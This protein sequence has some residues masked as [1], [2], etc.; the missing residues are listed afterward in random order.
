M[1]QQTE[2]G[3]V[4][5]IGNFDGVHRGHQAVLAA[6]AR[7]A[8]GL[9]LEAALLT[10]SPHPREALGR[11]V[12]PVLTALGRKLSLV[13]EAAPE[14]TP[15]VE[16]FDLAFAE[17]S[18][19]EFAGRVLAEK[20]RAKVVIVGPNFRFGKGRAGSYA[21]L[22][23]L[24]ARLGFTTHAPELVQDEKGVLSSTRVREALAA[25]DLD[26]AASILGRPHLVS[27]T[28]VEGD[29]RGRTIGFPTC[30]L[31]GIV[32]A[33]PAFGVYAVLVEREIEARGAGEPWGSAVPLAKGVAN[34]GVRPTVKPGETRP[35][36]EVHLFD[37]DQDLY[38][39]R[40]R[41]RLVA[42]LRA[43][44]R[45]SG[46]AELK[47]QIAKDAEAARRRLAE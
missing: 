4:V 26:E 46:L 6:A 20:L 38:G 39:A 21:T 25:G 13:R 2:P 8:K 32:E 31:A 34:I 11:P 35:S 16:R 1:E 9:G 7:E 43:E 23:E 30:N 15:I 14:V 28:V 45:F 33:L 27:G 22:G 36:V 5:A 19:E 47:A 12:P 40:L 3:R 18:P 41:V 37:T 29:K 10:F 17:Q 42:R 24:G 44:Q